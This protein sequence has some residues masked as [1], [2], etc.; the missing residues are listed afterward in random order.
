MRTEFR[1]FVVSIAMAATAFAADSTTPDRDAEKR[2]W[3]KYGR[4]SAAE[5]ARRD[6]SLTFTTAVAT[7]SA[8]VE[9]ASCCRR[10]AVRVKRTA[11]DERFRLKF[12]RDTAAVEMRATAHGSACCKHTD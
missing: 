4:Y 2:N 7:P 12:G 9:E 6:A 8:K 5:E 11:S 3:L 1:V 10:Q